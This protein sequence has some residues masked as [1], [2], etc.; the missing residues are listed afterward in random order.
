MNKAEKIECVLCKLQDQEIMA[1]NP[2]LKDRNTAMIEGSL[3]D[4]LINFHRL[5]KSIASQFLLGLATGKFLEN[6]EAQGRKFTIQYSEG[7]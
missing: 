3:L 7:K 5:P 1:L 6:M 2:R 4:H